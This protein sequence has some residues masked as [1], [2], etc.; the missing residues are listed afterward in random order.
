MF[1]IIN[2][3]KVKNIIIGKQLENAENL[4]KLL[5]IVSSKNIRIKVVKAGDRI[6]IEKDLY[7]NIIWPDSINMIS[8]NA[9]NNNALVC[10]L[11]YKDFTILFTGDIEEKAEEILISK[12]EKSNI[13]KSTILK[14]AH[15][16]S[17][18]SS[19]EGF[20][21]LVEPKIALIG[22]GKNNL[23]G[24]PNSNVIERLSSLGIEI[25]RTDEDGEISIST[26]GKM[27]K[28]KKFCK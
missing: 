18:T 26:N 28:I 19:T 9:I 1:Y 4:Q 10:K 5:E 25:F 3:I 24:H 13:L 12:Y 2:E 16:G 23:Y 7:F 17:K 22:V 27:Y 11:N 6:D 8:E 21:K 20:L 15:H 14:V